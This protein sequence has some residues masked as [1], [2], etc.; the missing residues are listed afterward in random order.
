[1]CLVCSFEGG[2]CPQET[3]HEQRVRF[4]PRRAREAAAE[5]HPTP[6]EIVELQFAATPSSPSGWRQARVKSCQHGLFLVAPTERLE[7][8]ARGEVIVPSTHIRPCV[9][10]SS[11]VAGWLH[12]TEVPVDPVLRDWLGTAQAAASL[13]Q[14]QQ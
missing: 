6:G 4:P 7:H 14:V 2:V 1:D 5:F 8:G 11:S 9:S 10:A 12:K 13:R 3:F